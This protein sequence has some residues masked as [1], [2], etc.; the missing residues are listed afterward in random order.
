MNQTEQQQGK[1]RQVTVPKEEKQLE[2][3][4]LDPDYRL[5]RVVPTDVSFS[6]WGT[7]NYGLFIPIAT[8]QL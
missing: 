1:N 8:S 2:V 6:T 5:N 3:D 4:E 7:Q